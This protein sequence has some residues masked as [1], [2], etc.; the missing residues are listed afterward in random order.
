MYANYNETLLLKKVKMRTFDDAIEDAKKQEEKETNSDIDATSGYEITSQYKLMISEEGEY[1]IVGKKNEEG[2]YSRDQVIVIPI[3]KKHI[4]DTTLR[5]KIADELVIHQIFDSKK[6]ALKEI[7]YGMVP[8]RKTYYKITS[9][10]ENQE[11]QASGGASF[12]SIKIDSYYENAHR[13]YNE[14]PFFFDKQCI[15]WLWKGNRWEITDDTEMERMLDNALGFMG[16]TVSSTIRKNHLTALKWVGRENKPKEAPIKWIQFKDKA[17]SLSS[18]KV[19]EVTPDYFF[20]NPIPWKIGENEDTPTIDKLFIEWVGEE[21]KDTLYEIIAYC[22][23]RDYP[24]HLIFCLIGAGRNG[25]SRFM[26][27]LNKFIGPENVCSTELDTLIDSRF[28]SFKLYKKLVCTMG[29]TNFGLL[30]KTS[31]LKKLSGQD[32]IGYEYKNK[33]PFDDYNYAKILISSNALPS[34]LD[35]S[36]GFYRRWLITEFPNV[37]PEGKDILETIPE[38]EYENLAKKLLSILPALIKKGEFTKQGSVEERKQRYVMASNPLSSF[39]SEHCKR[40]E[41]TYMKY[42]ELYLNYIKYLAKHKRRKIS[43]KEF[44]SVLDDEGLDVTKTTKYEGSD[45]INGYFIDGIE[46]KEEGVKQEQIE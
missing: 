25:K 7:A 46:M 31:L 35:T 5:N 4:F 6:K 15:W 33:Q 30:S 40:D 18:R 26:A 1:V 28:E 37:F 38:V 27:L 19:Y 12:N 42:S 45:P 10:K 24:I 32:M 9:K 41:T 34:S 22:C 2:I 44:K 39:I 13:F 14:Q 43:R 8:L 36:E 16:Q 21:Y 3:N 23:L 20:C 17:F 29:E 11:Y